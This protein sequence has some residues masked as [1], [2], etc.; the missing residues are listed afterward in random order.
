MLSVAPVPGYAQSKA[1]VDCEKERN[2]V[3]SKTTVPH[4][5]DGV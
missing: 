3:Q 2:P 4:V 5:P 1:E